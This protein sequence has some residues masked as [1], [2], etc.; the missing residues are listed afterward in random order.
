MDL[1]FGI[2]EGIAIL[3]EMS[4]K[5]GRFHPLSLANQADAA[6]KAKESEMEEALVQQILRDELK[7]FHSF[8]KSKLNGLGT[9][10]LLA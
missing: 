6:A 3:C 10:C 4:S 7:P 2:L 8:Q 9:I 1:A 5:L